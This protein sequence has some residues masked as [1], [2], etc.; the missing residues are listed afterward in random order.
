MQQKLTLVLGS[1]TRSSWSLRPWLFL[2]HHEVPFEEIVIP[3]DQKDTRARIL[4]H[5]PSGKV[6]CLLHG[7]VKVWESLA[8]CEYAAETLA[9]PAAWPMD[10]SA[11]ALARSMTSE[12]HAGFEK[13]RRELPFD[14][15][16]KPAP[17]ALGPQA[18]EE[19]ARVRAL[20]REARSQHG[21]GGPWLFGRFGIADAMYA[22]VALR[23]HAYGVELDGAEREYVF[24]LLMHPAVQE[25]LD[26]AAQEHP[27]QEPPLAETL[28]ERTAE[29]LVK[30]EP[31]P[32][33]LL[34]L[35]DL[36]PTTAPAAALAAELVPVP[37]AAPA[38]AKRYVDDPAVTQETFP[39]ADTHRDLPYDETQRDLR[40]EED[41][42]KA[43][44]V[45]APTVRKEELAELM[46]PRDPA[47]KPAPAK[48]PVIE[49][50]AAEPVVEVAPTKVRSV[51]MP[52]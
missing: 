14:A 18:A 34:E 32:P 13:L 45:V 27:A 40:P 44:A 30:P 5:S 20:W 48:N 21:R 12:M 51:I 4:D 46:A 9:L 15:L 50:G 38:A 35:L 37:V 7:P 52:P 22:P 25:W 36:P 49:T 24:N 39:A 19:V 10:P 16:R 31:E 6:P 3:L 1:K 41:Q 47:S 17:Q 11:R 2:R 29:I 8:I 26:A 23:F 28:A 43:G 42:R 33:E